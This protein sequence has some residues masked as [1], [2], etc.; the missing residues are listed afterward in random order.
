MN[1][2]RLYTRQD[3]LIALACFRVAMS[4]QTVANRLDFDLLSV[5]RWFEQYKKHD[6]N[7]AQAN[8]Q[9]YDLR[10]QALDYFEKGRGY[11]FV[12]RALNIPV[13]RVKY[14]HLRYRHGQTSFF[15]E[16]TRA[17]KQYS[18]EIKSEI[19][20][21]FAISTESKKAFCG[22]QKISVGTLNKWLREANMSV[23]K[24]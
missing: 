24:F 17:P 3:K 18:N 6:N 22:R 4:A 9:D 15:L 21:R 8:D 11:K 20:N 13:S 23:N 2:R 5:K 14:W 1:K 16:G 7:W 10:K 12:A 19:L